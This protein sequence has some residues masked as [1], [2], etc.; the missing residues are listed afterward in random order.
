MP[1]K[2][3]LMVVAGIAASFAGLAGTIIFLSEAKIISFELALLM[4]VALLGLYVGFGI[5]IA[6][7]R[8]ISKLD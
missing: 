7:Y 6:V 2:K 3:T 8:L 5:L 4:L 1:V